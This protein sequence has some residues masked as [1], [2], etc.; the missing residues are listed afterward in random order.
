MFM[1]NK[2]ASI[3]L[4]LDYVKPHA[5]VM[6]E[7]WF[8][9]EEELLSNF[10]GYTAARKVTSKVTVPCF[11]FSRAVYDTPTHN[12]DFDDFITNLDTH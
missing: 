8:Q 4:L 10:N 3:K 6:L 5:L 12:Y 7:T 1:H 2:V 11:L 9:S